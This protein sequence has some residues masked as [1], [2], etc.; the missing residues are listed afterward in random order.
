[1]QIKILTDT[2]KKLL[3]QVTLFDILKAL[4]FHVS[5]KAI[6]CKLLGLLRSS[7]GVRVRKK[8]QIYFL[9][10]FSFTEDSF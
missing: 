6:F 9:A 3:L 5:E 7:F 8:R 4:P 2:G 10:L 1:L